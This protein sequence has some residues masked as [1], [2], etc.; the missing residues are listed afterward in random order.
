MT[1][2]F[3]D[4]STS[5]GSR[6]EVFLRY[7]D[8]YRSRV[9]AKISELSEV[10]VS[11]SRLPSGWTPVE[12]LQ[13][14]AY[15]ERR[16]LEWGFEGRAVRDPWGD[17]QAGRWHV[18]DDTTVGHLIHA[19]QAQADRTRAIVDAHDLGDSGQPGDRWNGAE[20]ATLERI[21]LHL[22][23]EYARHLGQ[24]DIVAELAGGHVG[25]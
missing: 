18:P 6:A 4:P 11:R 25:E 7:L 13:H 19:L 1:V 8:Y 20:P 2:P 16:W 17:E 24:L 12:L 14:V 10:E 5:V 9:V 22:V 21:L 3:V 23:Q 15:V